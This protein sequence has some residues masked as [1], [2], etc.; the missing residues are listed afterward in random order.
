MKTPRFYLEHIH[1]QTQYLLSA[2]EGLTKEDF[3][4]NR[5]LILAFERSLE[6][7]GEAVARIDEAFRDAHPS[8][9]W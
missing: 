9:P 8:V 1:E 5:T 2:S 7:I 6:I 3:L 4:S